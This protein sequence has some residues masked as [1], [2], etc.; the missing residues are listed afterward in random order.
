MTIPAVPPSG[1][2]ASL[3]VLHIKIKFVWTGCVTEIIL[4]RYVTTDNAKG[5]GMAERNSTERSGQ[6]YG[7]ST[8]KGQSVPLDRMD[9]EIQL[10]QL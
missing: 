2:W 5:I 4:A 6:K 9:K 10:T 7:G 3:A 1:S 8:G